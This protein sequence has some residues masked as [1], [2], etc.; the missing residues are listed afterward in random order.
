M[1][2]VEGLGH[3]G[4]FDAKALYRSL[5]PGV[6]TVISRFPGQ[7]QGRGALGTGFVLDSHGF[8]ATNA[9]VVLGDPP[10]LQ[11]ALAVY[12]QFG[13]GNRVQAQVVGDDPFADVAL[14]KI[15]PRGLTLT[16]L[17]LGSTGNLA[18]GDP[19]AAIGSPFGEQQSLS[20]G[21]VSALH[22]SIDSLTN[23]SIQDAIQTDAAINHGNSG[24]PLIDEHG[25]VIGIN[26][27]IRST[28]GGG[29]GV[30]FAVSVETVKHSLAQLRTPPHVAR[31]AYLGVISENV[32]PQLARR[33]GLPVGR[34]ALVVKI[35][36][37]SPAQKAGLTSGSD[38]IEFQG[39]PGI[40]SGGDTIVAIDGQAVHSTNDVGRIVARH[41]PGDRVTVTV[42]R[43]H[44]RRNV[45]V[46][47]GIRPAKPSAG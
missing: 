12:V 33:L 44:K 43:G 28:G 5:A 18:V 42:L 19:V 14:L 38:K 20:V 13:D 11:K 7:G 21:V 31:Y 4:T 2:V 22:R 39:E 37:G 10:N 29:E 23:F 30:G 46:T 15:D 27:Q 25:R 47:F 9:H 32:W 6:V 17:K 41:L 16:P 3:S 40:P 34:G 36:A 24:G 8:L 35:Q 26:S 1:R 45:P